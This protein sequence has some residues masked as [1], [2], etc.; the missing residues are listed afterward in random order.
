MSRYLFTA[1]ALVAPALAQVAEC[2]GLQY[3]DWK[4]C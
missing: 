4:G 3:P 2:N 1:M